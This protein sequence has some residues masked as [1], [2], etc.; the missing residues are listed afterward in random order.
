[1]SLEHGPF[2]LRANVAAFGTYTSAPLIG[3]QTFGGK[4]T[5][6]LAAG[7]ALTNGIRFV[8]GVQNLFDARPDQIAGQELVIGAT[9]GSFPTGEETPI[10]LNGRSYYARLT[11]RF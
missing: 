5:V 9:G 6:D 11:A 4:E 8:L 3:A 2:D 10:G 7:Y 1:M